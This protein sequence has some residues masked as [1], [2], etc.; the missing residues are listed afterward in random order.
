MLFVCAFA[1]ASGTAAFAYTTDSGSGAGE[2]QAVTLHT[3]GA[4]SAS[5]PTT[6][7]LSLS[8]GSAPGLPA[9][10]GYLVL[11]STSSG[12]PYAKDSSG[13][14]QQGTTVNSAATSCVDSGLT[15]GTT[16]YYEIEAAYY[17]ISTPG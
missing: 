16:Y 1:I 10:G 14:C 11:R 8:W 17:D 13:T 9:R 4:G 7:S 12:G 3:P 5:K 6:T 2:A 15:A